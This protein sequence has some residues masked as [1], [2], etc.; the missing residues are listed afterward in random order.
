LV[1]DHGEHKG[2]LRVRQGMGIGK[3]ER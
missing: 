2:H 3:R 1:H